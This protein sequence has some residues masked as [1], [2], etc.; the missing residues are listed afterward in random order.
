MSNVHKVRMQ[1]RFE[2]IEDYDKVQK[3]Y[4][5]RGCKSLEQ[6]VQVLIGQDIHQLVEELR[7]RGVGRPPES[8]V[9]NS[10]GNEVA[11]GE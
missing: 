2:S 11:I 8:G 7:M 4:G 1:L 9:V 10:P 6:Y 3:V 5:I